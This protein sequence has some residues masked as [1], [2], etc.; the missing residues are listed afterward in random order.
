M[1]YT[2]LGSSIKAG[3]NDKLIKFVEKHPKKLKFRFDLS[4]DWK[5]EDFQ[6]DQYQI[7]DIQ[8]LK[9]TE[10]LP[11]LS[12][13]KTRTKSD[14]L[15]CCSLQRSKKEILICFF[16]LRNLF[17]TTQTHY[18]CSISRLWMMTHPEI[19]SWITYLRRRGKLMWLSCEEPRRLKRLKYSHKTSNLTDVSQHLF[20]WHHS[21]SD[22][23]TC[24]IKFSERLYSYWCSI[25]F[26]VCVNPML[27]L[28]CLF[29][30][31]SQSLILYFLFTH[32][33][34]KILNSLLETI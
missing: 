5:P 24:H 23:H 17:P 15:S 29:I 11:S 31:P 9:L 13:L 3:K 20:W 7:V 28:L 8:S 25:Y 26:S 6:I 4:N 34:R 32:R 10:F 18:S 21:F 27:H 30:T 19:N 33:R 12:R 2:T 1:K 22:I 14:F 16:C